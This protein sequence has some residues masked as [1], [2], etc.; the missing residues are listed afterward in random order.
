MRKKTVTLL[1]ILILIML[2]SGCNSDMKENIGFYSTDEDV[3]DIETPYCNLQ[4]PVEWEDAVIISNEE[5][6]NGYKVNFVAVIEGDELPLFD[7]VFES[8]EGAPLG[9]LKKDGKDISVS[10]ISY[11]PELENY[12]EDQQMDFAG[13]SEDINVIISKLLEQYEFELAM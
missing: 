12:T 10:L 6:D 7:I 8:N 5:L 3:F 1:V 13:M 2:F 9:T 11:N 4:Y